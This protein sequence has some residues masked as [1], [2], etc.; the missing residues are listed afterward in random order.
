MTTLETALAT[1]RTIT[2]ITITLDDDPGAL[3]G[4]RDLIT[5]IDVPASFARF[6]NLV[7]A[8]IRASWTECATADIT[9]TGSTGAS[10]TVTVYTDD[11]SDDGRYSELEDAIKGLIEGIWDNSWGDKGNTWVVGIDPSTFECSADTDEI[12]LYEDNAGHLFYEC[13]SKVLS[14]V[15]ALEPLRGCFERDA[16]ALFAGEVFRPADGTVCHANAIDLPWGDAVARFHRHDTRLG[17]QMEVFGRYGHAAREALGR[18]NLWVITNRGQIL[19]QRFIQP[20][21][22]NRPADFELCDDEQS[23]IGGGAAGTSW[24]VIAD[25]D[26]RITPQ[27]RQSLGWVYEGED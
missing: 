8:E 24:D 13:G 26:P 23:W 15:E 10:D 19:V 17:G 16:L 3:L 9:V 4:D 20:D 18:Q 2:G 22:I 5:H 25:D 11:G 14:G 7:E 21:G 1:T 6:A 27:I 12:L